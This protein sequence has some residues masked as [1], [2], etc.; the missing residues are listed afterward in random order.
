MKQFRWI[1]VLGI[2]AVLLCVI[3]FIVD[4]AAE[5]EEQQQQIGAA[6]ALFRVDSTTIQRITLENEEG[7]YAFDWDSEQKTW[8]IASAEQFNLNTYAISTSCNYFCELD[9]LKTVAFD[10][11]DTATYGFDNPVTL[12]VYTTDTGEDKPY[13]LYIGDN[14]PTYDAYY[15]MVEGS[16]DVYTINYTEGSV[17]CASKD[18]LK[19]LYLFDT[20]S[21]QVTHYEVF[22]GDDAIVRLTRDEEN[23]WNMEVPGTYRVN[24]ANI[25]NM[26]NT[27]IRVTLVGFV[28]ENPTDLAQYGLDNPTHRLLLEGYSGTKDMKEE[29]WIGNPASDSADEVNVYGYFVDSKQVFLIKKADLTFLDN[30]PVSYIYPYCVDIDIIDLVSVDIDMGDVYDMKETLYV[31]Y[32]NGEYALSDIKID[33]EDDDLITLFQNFYRAISN[34]EFTALDQTAQPAGEAA[35]SITYNKKD[36][37]SVKVE[38]VRLAENNFALVVDGVYDGRT[39]RLNRFTG[40]AGIVKSYEALLRGLDTE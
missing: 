26:I 9:S 35:I 18:T 38:F 22:K 32:E 16:N 11:Q 29:V 10:C 13:V 37:T 21:T 28:E 40:S 31:D 6:K 33:S 23:L 15:A 7:Y 12:K 1:W 25:E 36:G 30:D 24:S 2:V 3:Y 34:L 8:V 20:F 4:N 39:V 5:Q 17:F 27:L 14:T 19:N